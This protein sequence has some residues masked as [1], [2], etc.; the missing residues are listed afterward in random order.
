MIFLNLFLGSIIVVNL[1]LDMGDFDVFFSDEEVE[2]ED[3]EVKV[4]EEEDVFL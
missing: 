1:F 2:M 4:D 3:V